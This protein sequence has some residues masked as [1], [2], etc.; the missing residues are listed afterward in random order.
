[1]KRRAN[2]WIIPVVLALATT[3]L[4][5]WRLNDVPVHVSPDEAIISVDAYSL[6]RTGVDVHGRFLPLY[7]LVQL[8]GETRMGW[9]TPAIFYLSAL[10]FRVL[11]FS[12]SAIRV[13]T[14]I[15]AV[16]DVVLTYFVGR[17]L[18]GRE[19]SAIVAAVLLAATPAHLILGRYALDYLYPLPFVLGWLYCL[20][21]FLDCDRPA[22]LV[23][24]GLILGVG[25]Y[26]Y[27]A[28]VVMMPLYLLITWA[29]VAH[30]P[31]PIGL[32]TAS[33]VGFALPLLLLIP[34]LLHHPTAVGDTVDRY[35]LYDTKSLN[36]FQGIRSF[37]GYANLERLA[38]SYWSFF[39]PSFL[40]FSGDKQMT[41][42]TRAVGVFLWPVAVLL[43]V[44]F[45]AAL[46]EAKQVQMRLLLVGFLTAP[47]AALLGSE[48]GVI[49][50]AVELLPFAVL[51]AVLGVERLWW[52]S[53][54]LPSRTL[55]LAAAVALLAVVVPYG[56]WSVAVRGRIGMSTLG[57][58]MLAGSL[59]VAATMP[60]RI[61]L[62]RA[63]A[64]LMVALVPLQFV[65]FATDYFAD[66]RVRS[67]SWLGGNTR[68]ALEDL[69]DRDQK[70]RVPRI[71][72]ST[73]ASTGGLM[74][75]RNRWMSTYWQFYLIKH[76]RVDL[77]RRTA[78][79]NPAQVREVPPGSLVLA[80]VG[81]TSVEAL[82]RSGELTQVRLIPEMN[83]EP[84]FAILRR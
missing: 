74:D 29:S 27:I 58:T 6:S 36:M 18:F 30:K 66:Y 5:A 67:S 21:A 20:L 69:I 38:T 47:V 12:E 13:P 71:Y 19:S 33:A 54:R 8:P 68:G 23:G 24:A 43:V 22:W 72:F 46:I 10:V 45:R 31:R 57:V 17:R 55:P 16:A 56:A 59:L 63:L 34:W 32:W 50:R 62:G 7:F 37:F 81:E 61:P 84:F 52:A 70:E 25:F 4:Y 40:F 9:F 26:S 82:I 51:L 49:T 11:P 44:G 73:L 28:A 2:P 15:V 76:G 78:S 42:S 48:D 79:L 53:I 3:T 14:V 80:N 35:A 64:C 77:L 1:M 75:I 39:S 65:G 60:D 83:G 41:F